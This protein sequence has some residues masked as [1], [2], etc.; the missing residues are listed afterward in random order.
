MEHVRYPSY[1]QVLLIVADVILYFI[2]PLL[3]GTGGTYMAF[4]MRSHNKMSKGVESDDIGHHDQ[5][6][7]Q[8]D[9]H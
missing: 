6:I 1:F 4:F 2:T 3:F 9:V 5:F 7:C 8:V